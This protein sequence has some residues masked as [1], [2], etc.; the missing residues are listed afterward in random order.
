MFFFSRKRQEKKLRRRSQQPL[1]L[2]ALE[3]RALLS[4]T[5]TTLLDLN[6]L[7]VDP[8]KYSSIDILVRLQE[9]PGQ[10]GGPAIVA[11]TTLGSQLPLTNGFYQID[12]GKGM[13]VANAL[14]A[15]KAEKG[16]LDAE[17]D[18]ELSVSSVPNDPLL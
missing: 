7:T 17:P 12:L 2:E 11:G 4:T 6:R 10:T 14:S 1:T 16:V 8:S 3:D 9:T 18:Y 13:T 5:P 15:Y